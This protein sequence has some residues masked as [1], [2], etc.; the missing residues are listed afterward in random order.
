MRVCVSFCLLSALCLTSPRGTTALHPTPPQISRAD[1]SVSPL[2]ASNLLRDWFLSD[3][4]AAN[5][6]GTGN[7]QGVAW[8]E[9]KSVLAWMENKVCSQRLVC[10]LFRSS[11]VSKSCGARP[12]SSPPGV[13][14]AT[15]P[16]IAILSFPR[17]R[18]PN[19]FFFA[20]FPFVPDGC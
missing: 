4:S 12:A 17:V 3:G 5:A 18:P 8:E 19:P 15:M 10:L 20:H 11:Q 2:A 14:I 7:D 6:G 16:G 1:P 9:D 13:N